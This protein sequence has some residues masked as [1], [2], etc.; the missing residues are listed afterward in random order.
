[1]NTS[2]DPLA[3][4]LRPR[5]PWSSWRGPVALAGLFATLALATTAARARTTQ[6]PADTPAEPARPAGAVVLSDGRV[7][8][9]GGGPGADDGTVTTEAGRASV[10]FGKD[11]RGRAHSG[12][13][14]LPTGEVLVTGGV[15]DGAA[16]ADAFVLRESPPV[17]DRAV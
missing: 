16:T 7:L 2:R 1:M 9:I 6:S 12:V 13:A 11:W 14:V 3:R 15:V 5:R 8:T 10:S 17:N 4:I